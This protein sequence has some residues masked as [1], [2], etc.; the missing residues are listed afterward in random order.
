MITGKIA[1]RNFATWMKR[2]LLSRFRFGFRAARIRSKIAR[3]RSEIG[4][5][6]Q[7]RTKPT[8]IPTVARIIFVIQSYANWY[9]MVM[10]G[11]QCN[12]V[13]VLFKNTATFTT[14]VLSASSNPPTCTSRS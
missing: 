12:A 4:R 5:A 14:N 6:A 11:S 10:V 3:I 9:W 13:P 2:P 1:L 8:S 7:P